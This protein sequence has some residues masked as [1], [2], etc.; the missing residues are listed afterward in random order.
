MFFPGESILSSSNGLPFSGPSLTFEIVY[1]VILHSLGMGALLMISSMAA[2]M[3]LGKRP[4]PGSEEETPAQ[5]IQHSAH[6]LFMCLAICCLILLVENN[7]ARAFTL[8]A[9]I[10]LIRFKT[11]LEEKTSST[12]LLFG[13]ICGMSAGVGIPRVGWMLAAL[14][15]LIQLTLVGIVQFFERLRK[16]QVP[17]ALSE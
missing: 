17:V 3:M 15:G 7:L 14:Y 5:L 16:R 2:H 9:A 8:G 1:P 4:A 12:A 11:K 10:A 13:I 6:V